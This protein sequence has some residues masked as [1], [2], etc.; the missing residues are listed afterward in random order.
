MKLIVESGA[1]K[2]DWCAIRSDGTIGKL[3]TEGMN[4]STMQGQSVDNLIRK[5][6]SA[7][8]SGNELVSEV[9]FYAAGLI[10]PRTSGSVEYASDLLAAA[11]ALCGHESGIAAILG[12]GSNSCFYD[13][14]SIVKNVRSGGFI[15]GDEGSAASL[16]KMFISDYLKGLVPEDLAK[17]FGASFT[18]DYGTVVKNVYKGD[19]PSRYLGSF[20][21]WLLDRYDESDYVNGLVKYNF[22]LF[23]ERALGR[24]DFKDYPVGVVGGFAYRLKDV[25]TEVAAPYGIRISNILE[26]PLEGLIKYHGND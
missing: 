8:N 18:V 6:I 23:I 16:G 17:E 1:T 20:T 11:R 3:R 13:G 21:P 14:Q 26:S 19:S 24:Y 15:L 22:R 9:H 10:E 4:L 5:A 7:L 2:T 12:T 25:F